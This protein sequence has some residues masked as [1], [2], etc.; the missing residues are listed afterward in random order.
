MESEYQT[1]P[2]DESKTKETLE[3][4]SK[5]QLQWEVENN[6]KPEIDEK[7]HEKENPKTPILKELPVTAPVVKQPDSNHSKDVPPPALSN[8]TK[9]ES[10]SSSN[11]KRKSHYQLDPIDKTK[12][13]YNKAN[14]SRDLP[15]K[16]NTLKSI[17]RKKSVTSSLSTDSKIITRRKLWYEYIF[18]SLFE[19]PAKLKNL[20][21][22]LV[23]T[24]SRPVFAGLPILLAGS[25]DIYIH[26]FNTLY[27]L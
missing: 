17:E 10:D 7:N 2:K 8:D 25:S 1:N 4:K 27:N 22:I 13:I 5:L 19:D 14:N 9:D 24:C 12:Y 26:A 21:L 16:E 15:S 6:K 11:N 23:I 18:G 3:E 20:I